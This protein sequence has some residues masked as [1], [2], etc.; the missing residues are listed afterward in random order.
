MPRL[1]LPEETQF[2]DVEVY[3]V[4]SIPMAGTPLDMMDR[5]TL[6]NT[7]EVS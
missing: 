1:S 7:E 4:D 6:T 3:R 2:A 5:L